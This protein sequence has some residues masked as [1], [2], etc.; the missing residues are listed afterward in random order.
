MYSTRHAE[1]RLF[2][3]TTNRRWTRTM[4]RL[5]QRQAQAVFGALQYDS[6]LALFCVRKW[7]SYDEPLMAAAIPIEEINAVDRGHL[8]I[9]AY[10]R[11]GIDVVK[12]KIRNGLR[13]LPVLVRDFSINANPTWCG[14][15]FNASL[16]MP[17][18]YKYQ[19]LDGFKRFVAYREL[20][21]QVISC[22]IDNA[23][24]PG[25]QH[26]MSWRV[27]SDKLAYLEYQFIKTLGDRVFHMRRG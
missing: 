13:I 5:Y 19:R 8:T 27:R 16:N 9:D 14:Q 20:G 6:R 11:K 3:F 23:A 15:A 22:Y 4:S 1:A 24:F 26:K 10:H 25:A 17:T 21:Y 2:L 12:T 18:N 7:R